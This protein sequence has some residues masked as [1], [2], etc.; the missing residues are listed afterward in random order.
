[1]TST[2]PTGPKLQHRRQHEI[3]A[4][5]ITHGAVDVADL[6]RRF[7]VTTETI[8]RDLSDLQGRR[9]LRR[10]HGG[11][12]ALESARHEPNVDARDR[13]NMDEKARIATAATEFV[14]AR[15]AIIIDSGSTGH[16]LA[17]VLQVDRDIHVVTNS[18]KTA[19]T[20][21]RR[22]VRNLTVLGG[23]VHSS[24]LAM[25]DVT[26]RAAL[27]GIAVDVA[28]IGC[29]GFSAQRGLTTPYRDEQHMKRAMA[30][31]ADQ[32][33]A[34]IDQSKLDNNQ[35]FCVAGLHEIDVLITDTRADDETAELLTSVGPTV[36]RV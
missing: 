33:V 36:L 28:F 7:E 35:M 6:A 10:V 2:A 22:G 3:H 12:V 17:E 31:R 5:A 15:G 19:L 24:T 30:A 1:M 27:E 21:C 8:R 25:T 18:L 14:P 20:L 16:C 26:A 9:L 13:V 4:L 29:D 34:L 11:A 23:A 32:V